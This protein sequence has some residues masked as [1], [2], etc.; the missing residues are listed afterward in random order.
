MINQK[1]LDK[2][3]N[4]IKKIAVSKQQITYGMLYSQIGVDNRDPRERKRGSDVLTEINKM[5]LEEKN[6]MITTVVVK[7]DTQKPGGMY[8]GLAVEFGKLKKDASKTEK[9]VF[10]LSERKRVYK[11]FDK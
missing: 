10:L 5:S 8:F 7:Q 11:A 6:V 1:L 2:T 3:Y 4:I 9:D